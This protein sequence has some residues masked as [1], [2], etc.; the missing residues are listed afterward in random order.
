MRVNWPRLAVALTVIGAGA[1]AAYA[2]R[3]E[4]PVGGIRGVVLAEDSG[5]ALSGATVYLSPADGGRSRWTSTGAD[6]SYEFTG[7]P[8]GVYQIKAST[9]AHELAPTMI[10]VDEGEIT[11]V[12]LEL[13]PGPPFLEIRTTRHVFGTD[14]TPSALFYGFL[15]SDRVEVRLYRID[16]L[17]LAWKERG[18][19]RNLLYTWTGREWAYDPAKSGKLVLVSTRQVELTSKDV[20]GIFKQRVAVDVDGPGAY[21][22]EARSGNVIERDWIVVSDIALITKLAGPRLLARVVDRRSGRPIPGAEVAAF[23]R[24]DRL[25]TG[26]TDA[27]GLVDT[28]LPLNA[29]RNNYVFAAASWQGS[30]AFTD[31]YQWSE[32]GSGPMRVFAYT[33]RPVYRPG[34]EVHFKGIVR[35]RRG[36]GYAVP[37]SLPVTV[38]VRDE[39]DT[40]IYRDRFQTNAYGSYMGTL[41]LP[42]SAVSGYY[43]VAATVNGK[44]NY[45]GFKI[46]SYTKPEYKVDV[47]TDKERYTLG[48]TVH[49]TVKAD[50]Y[51]GA[52]LVGAQVYY[53]IY[54]SPRYDYEYDEAYDESYSGYGYEYETGYGE[55]VDYGDGRTDK[56]GRFVVKFKTERGEADA[57]PDLDNSL[58][59][60][61]TVEANVSEESWAYES[62]TKSMLVTAGEFGITLSPASWV[63]SP[64]SPLDAAV[65]VEDHDGKPQSGVR[66]HVT[67]DRYDWQNRAA[68]FRTV[69][70]RDVTTGKDGK[71]TVGFTPKTAGS[72][73]IRASARDRRK[74]TL[75]RS[76]WIW[77]TASA[78]A[79]LGGRISGVD[80]VTD[81]RE[82]H[83]GDTAKLVINTKDKGARALLCVEGDTLYDYRTIDLRGTTSLVDL[84]IKEEYAPNVFVSV[85]YV[86]DGDFVSETRRVAVSLASRALQVKV[87]PSKG[88]L[89]PGERITYDIET[90]DAEGR[91][92]PAEVSLGVVDE[93]IY[94]VQPDTTPKML[95]FFY[96]PRRNLVETQFSSPSIYL[97]ADKSPVAM[98][99][100][101]EFRDTAFWQPAV[102]TDSRG[103]ATIA[104]ALPDN[105][106]TWRATA[107]AQTLATA[108][109]EATSKVRVT[110]P[111]LVR[112]SAPRFFTQLDEATVSGIVHNYTKNRQDVAVK[113][114]AKGFRIR[115]GAERCV[116][117]RPDEVRRIDWM[118][119]IPDAGEAR[120]TLSARAES[121]PSD[122]MEVT[123]PCLPH[124]RPRVENRVGVVTGTTVEKLFLSD[125]AI[126][127]ATGL[128]I[129]VGPSVV[130]SM[131]SA[132]D[133]LA[134]YPYGCT[135][136]TMSA[137]LPDVILWRTLKR[138]GRSDPD[139][140]RRLPDMVA[141]ALVRLY[142]KHHDDGGWGWWEYDESNFWMTAYVLNGLLEARDAGFEVRP[143][144]IN[145]GV[146]WLKRRLLGQPIS[147]HDLAYGCY[148]LSATQERGAIIGKVDGLAAGMSSLD[149]EAL[150]MLALTLHRVGRADDA[151]RAAALLWQ[152]ADDSRA[153]TY[154]RSARRRAWFD[155]NVETT[156]WCLKAV[157]AVT[158]QDPRIAKVARW[159]AMQRRG[160][161]W[162]STK[163][164]ALMIDAL[165]SYVAVTSALSPDC[166]VS[167]RVNGQRVAALRFTEPDVWDPEV[168]IADAASHLIPGANE[169]TFAKEGRGEIAYSVT[170]RQNV[171]TKQVGRLVS[172][173]GVRVERS[174]HR[175]AVQTDEESWTP[176]YVAEE[177]PADRVRAG[178]IILVRLKVS[179]G[180]PRDYVLVEDP[181]PAGCRVV[182]R[183][184]ISPWAW[185]RWWSYM[186]VRD[187]RVAVFVTHLPPGDHVI[188]YKLRAD[189]PGKYA[190]MPTVTYG[191]Y[192]PD[193]RGSG[194]ET[195]LEIRK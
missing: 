178:D 38:E 50:Y 106:T 147:K 20:E 168:I 167:V 34:Q 64:G 73:R 141:E 114:E 116:K 45:S 27:D 166:T 60:T 119:D 154:W 31:S 21:M 90:K 68:R 193:I 150:A 56:Q 25:F 83:I 169:V 22:L 72:Y 95:G 81:K 74:N 148:V 173:S 24:K 164:T 161:C 7:V 49:A 47:E 100:R 96:P 9:E 191:M 138:L 54:R 195:R 160:D 136:Q 39:A 123:I 153:F 139:L 181:I 69:E 75:V 97:D 28:T 18:S 188:E 70:S 66:L 36:V 182:E 16:F 176:R 111:L 80:I 52:P 102:I 62:R 124:G 171:F 89:G 186:D 61:Y 184:D 29:G 101:K 115:G 46:A 17:H 137:F 155:N 41:A 23:D 159:A 117:L 43:Q 109:G 151:G 121:G 2:V 91:G 1:L 183:T 157:C 55:I 146:T 128:E 65:K 127:P 15:D 35:E 180:T 187:D 179:A 103:K 190:A 143:Y 59:Y 87:K 99:V 149:P 130:A 118:V 48:D 32:D 51:F 162:V 5:A 172:G 156:A 110:K 26:T 76:E 58:D 44:Q 40:L 163:D 14:E 125:K 185:D 88:V 120:V 71:A 4:T 11:T 42:R 105:L 86:K 63:A 142:E 126:L 131:F 98:E 174:Y 19:L 57:D 33:D 189:V 112:L 8:I 122:A 170:L 79:D 30:L 108:V 135:E 78:Y 177:K 113:L 129:R 84:P 67:L 10:T 134:S 3:F 107:R 94:A 140:E 104:F 13:A 82:Y 158:P 93:A 192:E 12:D 53:T 145:S 132:L 77:V 133:Y 152:R 37:A 165:C 194:D 144:A 92:V 6:G 175:L 85:C